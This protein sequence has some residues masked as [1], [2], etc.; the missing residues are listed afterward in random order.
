MSRAYTSD[1]FERGDLLA[2]QGNNGYGI[3]AAS[4]GLTGTY[5]A[6][7][8]DGNFRSIQTLS[9]TAGTEVFGQARCLFGSS[10]GNGQLFMRYYNGAT[11]GPYITLDASRILRIYDGAANLLA[12]AASPLTINATGVYLIQFHCLLDAVNGAVEVRVDG[13]S[14]A[15]ASGINT[16]R[17]PITAIDR[18]QLQNF[19]GGR[20]DPFFDDVLVNVNDGSGTEDSW[21]G[22]SRFAGILPNGAGH[23]TGLTSSNAS[24]NYQNV[25]TKPPTNSAT[26]YNYTSVSGNYDSYSPGT[27]S[28]TIASTATIVGVSV[29][30]QVQTYN[31]P[32]TGKV[33]IYTGLTDYASSAINLPTSYGRIANR[34]RLNPNT[35]VIWTVTQAEAAQPGV[36][37]T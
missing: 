34:W 25:N 1:G 14:Y 3:I 32:Q 29:D 35:G 2:F 33:H 13:V 20:T 11:A 9:W 8:L 17:G 6:A 4:A 5:A 30:A 12:T 21:A 24:A 15:S 28:A 31:A 23:V 19:A 7:S 26:A 27:P 16:T 37:L 18:L 36:G 10:N 22:D